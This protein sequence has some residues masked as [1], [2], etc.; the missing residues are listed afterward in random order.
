MLAPWDL[1]T[2]LLRME[3][4]LQCDVEDRQLSL[5]CQRMPQ[6]QQ[7]MFVLLVEESWCSKWVQ[8]QLRFLTRVH[9]SHLIG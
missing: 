4:H 7:S 6:C 2:E 8:E 3:H 1:P 9:H 5:V